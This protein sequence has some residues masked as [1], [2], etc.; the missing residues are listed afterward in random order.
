MLRLQHPDGHPRLLLPG[1]EQPDVRTL[2]HAPALEAHHAAAR[3]LL[4]RGY[5]QEA[6][7]GDEAPVVPP[8]V[9]GD[10]PARPEQL[11]L[12]VLAGGPA[13]LA[14]SRRDAAEAE[15]VVDP[16]RGALEAGAQRED[17][18]APTG[19]IG[20]LRGHQRLIRPLTPLL[21][22]GVDVTQDAGAAG[23]RDHHLGDHPALQV[24]DVVA[25]LQVVQRPLV[26]ALNM[27]GVRLPFV[28]QE[29]HDPVP[30]LRVGRGDDANLHPLAAL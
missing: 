21:G 24:A 6:Q 27:A 10:D 18:E 23:A 2:H 29:R 28:P 19:H 1:Q 22:E 17:L 16:V 20:H 13:H 3:Q 7:P 25:G 26:R 15:T 4:V 12:R 9:P 11:G 5:R 30:P 14:A 8:R